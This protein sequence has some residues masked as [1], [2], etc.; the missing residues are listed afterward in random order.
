[1]SCQD[2]LIFKLP[3][4]RWETMDEKCASNFLKN[5]VQKIHKK[6]RKEETLKFVREIINIK[7]SRVTDQKK[8]NSLSGSSPIF[9]SVTLDIRKYPKRL[10]NIAKIYSIET[11]SKELGVFKLA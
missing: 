4:N 5:V 7:I 3:A 11:L 2:H 9:N 8:D 6:I 10:I 1:M